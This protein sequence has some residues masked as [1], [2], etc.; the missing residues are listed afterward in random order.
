M[1]G[2]IPRI[3]LRMATLCLPK[4]DGRHKAGHDKKR[5]ANRRQLW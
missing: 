3:P 2:F 5:I 1:R 4:R